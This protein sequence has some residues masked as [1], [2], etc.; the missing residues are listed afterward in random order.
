MN[1][2]RLQLNK[3]FIYSVALTFVS[4]SLVWMFVTLAG[5][6]CQ[7]SITHLAMIT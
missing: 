3:Y 7:N 5:D 6:V 4:T 2:K 1:I